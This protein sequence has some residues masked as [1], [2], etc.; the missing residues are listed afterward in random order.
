MVSMCA[1]DSLTLI[2]GGDEKKEGEGKQGVLWH[3][4][5]SADTPAVRGPEGDLFS[6]ALSNVRLGSL[7]NHWSPK[8]SDTGF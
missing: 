7:R 1:Q 5:P 8:P 4:C 2:T 3:Q 6:P